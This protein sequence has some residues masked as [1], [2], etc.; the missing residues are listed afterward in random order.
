MAAATNLYPML[1]GMVAMAS[2]VAGLAFL[3]FWRRSRDP[4]FV[5]FCIAFFVDAGVR[6]ATG[7]L[8]VSD[9]HEAYYYL[10][11]LLTFALI[12]W[13]IVDKNR[14]AHKGGSS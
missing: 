10:P 3:R 6:I 14:R 12:G 4:L 13:A 5:Y 8:S 11:R 1:A 2:L 7:L 9:E